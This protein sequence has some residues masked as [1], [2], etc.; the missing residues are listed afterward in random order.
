VDDDFV[1][2]DF[3][4]GGGEDSFFGVAADFFDEIYGI[5]RSN[6]GYALLDDW[7]LVEFGG[8]EVG[9]GSDEFDSAFVRHFV[10]FCTD[11]GW[12]ERV[13]D[14]DDRTAK[15]AEELGREDFHVPGEGEDVGVEF[16]DDFELSFFEI[17]GGWGVKKR[18]F[19]A[20]SDGFGVAEV[21]DDERDF[22]FFEFFCFDFGEN[23][24]EGVRLAGGENSEFL[25][26]AEKVDVEFS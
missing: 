1:F 10:R 7:S 17:F 15:F 21:G 13:V 22:D 18:D 3:F 26:F 9:G 6:R 11:E 25:G 20:T 2:E 4:E 5:P 24:E 8:G 12:E 14:V 16:F 19:V 23:F